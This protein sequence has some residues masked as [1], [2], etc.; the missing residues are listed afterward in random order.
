MNIVQHAVPYWNPFE[1]EY[2]QILG[3]SF[4]LLSINLFV[5]VQEFHVLQ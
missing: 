1:A 5:A 3:K 2:L 4:L